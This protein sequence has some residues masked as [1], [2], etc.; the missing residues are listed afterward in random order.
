MTMILKKGMI[1]Y[2][3]M[4]GGVQMSEWDREKLE[5]MDHGEKDTAKK[6][7]YVPRPKWQLALAWIAVGI[8]AFAFLGTIYWMVA[9]AH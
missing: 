2:K 9:F 7:P 5:N 4:S 6:E 3:K 8:V 1:E